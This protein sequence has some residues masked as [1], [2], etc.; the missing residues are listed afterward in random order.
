MPLFSRG[1]RDRDQPTETP[2]RP[3]APVQQTP[4]PDAVPAVSVEAAAADTG[5]EAPGH[6]DSPADAASVGISVS[7]YRGVGAAPQP[8]AKPV[9]KPAPQPPRASVR[10][11]A[12]PTTETLPGLRDNVLLAEALSVL[13]NPPTPPQILE[14]VRQLLQGQLILRVKGDARSLLAQG[15]QPPLAVAKL[16]DETFVLVFSGGA[17]LS[18]SVKRDGDTD[19]SAMGQSAL[20]ILRYVLAGPHAGIVID[21][22]SAPRSAVLRRPMLEKIF[23]GIDPELTIKTLLVSERTP[24]TPA[25][26]VDALTRVAF[27]VAVRRVGESDRLGV[28]EARTAEGE[29]FIEIFSHPLEVVALGRGDQPAPMTGE[30]LGKALASDAQ[31]T[32]VLVDPAGP[33]IKLTR[34]DLAGIIPA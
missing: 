1:K 24:A 14:V 2:E 27:W 20:A 17:A 31:L 34:A 8:A 6:V 10:E 33:W 30:Q 18:E 3:A 15:A 32:G 29:R 12:P 13:D 22:A 28:A 4:I 7:A 25:A 19:T 11:L 23:E 9:A 26:V 5:A 21:P 16:G